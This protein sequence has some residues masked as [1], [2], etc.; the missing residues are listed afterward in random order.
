M[1]TF[2]KKRGTWIGRVLAEHAGL[3]ADVVLVLAQISEFVVHR[4]VRPNE[5]RRRASYDILDL[6]LRQFLGA[7][8][9]FVTCSHDRAISFPLD[10]LVR[11]IGL[12]FGILLLELRLPLFESVIFAE[13]WHYDLSRLISCRVLL[14]E[15]RQVVM[16]Q[17]P[18][19]LVL[20]ILHISLLEVVIDEPCYLLRLIRRYAI[21]TRLVV[22]E[23]KEAQATDI[24][25]EIADILK[26]R[27]AQ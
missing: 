19:D 25:I 12:L 5:Y 1:V 17:H 6:C 14:L 13:I 23:F 22:P 8:R 21:T 16:I 7:S 26:V 2:F 3:E 4:E 24:A 18:K 9:P 15:G 10:C 27:S 20:E 11:C